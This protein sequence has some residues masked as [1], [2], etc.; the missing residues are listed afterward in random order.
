MSVTPEHVLSD[1]SGLW[2]TLAKPGAE[3]AAGV[4]RACAM[5]LVVLAE[6]SDDA[7]AI[8]ETLAALMPEH[9]SRAILVRLQPGRS[10]TLDARVFAQCWLPFGQ[11]RQIC[12]E[13]VEITATD[14]ALEDLSAFLL[15]LTVPD[16]PVFLW[17]RSPRLFRSAEWPSV[18]SVAHRVLIDSA[19]LGEPGAALALIADRAGSGPRLADLCWTRVTRWRSLVSQIFENRANLAALARIREVRMTDAG[20]ISR[21]L[22]A[23]LLGGLKQA[24]A[25]AAIVFDEAAGKLRHVV[26]TAPD[27]EFSITRN[28]ESCAEIAA[29]GS[30]HRT[31]LP[32]P[33]EYALLRAELAITGPD[34]IFEKV[35]AGA[36][37]LVYRESA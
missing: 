17:C 13:Q 3:T 24:G 7:S 21:Y 18:A 1:L 28:S 11:R 5:T 33:T 9:P 4:L 29:A 30:L 8:G 36:R 6:E 22:G 14:A 34:P 20:V 23:W 31:A 19:L 15:P 32:V 27:A 35:L 12:C 2:G 26:L 25:D 10:R 37:G 16:L